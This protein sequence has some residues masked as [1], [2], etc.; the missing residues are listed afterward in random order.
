MTQKKYALFYFTLALMLLVT[1]I[2]HQ[3]FY[4]QYMITHMHTAEKSV[5]IDTLALDMLSKDDEAV[6]EQ[7]EQSENIAF[8]KSEID[9]QSKIKS[10]EYFVKTVNDYVNASQSTHPLNLNKGWRNLMLQVKIV[11]LLNPKDTE[12][13]NMVSELSSTINARQ[14]RNI[15]TCI[16]LF[17]GWLFVGLKFKNLFYVRNK[18]H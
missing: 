13:Q 2:A 16:T 5:Q 10:T 8:C 7:L 18:H 15:I 14:K 11:S 3:S 9:R 17:F 12:M 4:T 6:C 1:A